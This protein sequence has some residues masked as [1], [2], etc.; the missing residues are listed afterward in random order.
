MMERVIEE[1]IGSTLEQLVDI[2]LIN[3]VDPTCEL[4]QA[5]YKLTLV[6]RVLKELA[7]GSDHMATVRANRGVDA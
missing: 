6:G 5:Q 4:D 1:S 7:F 2:N 3:E